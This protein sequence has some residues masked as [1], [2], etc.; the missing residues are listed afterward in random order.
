MYNRKYRKGDKIESLDELMKQ[1]FV[2]FH[3][4]VT[5]CGWFWQW[6]IGLTYSYIKRG[7]ENCPKQCSATIA[8][9]Y[10]T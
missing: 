10:L 7:M 1:D 6:R 8:T 4:K 9:L 2:F 5:H 3:D